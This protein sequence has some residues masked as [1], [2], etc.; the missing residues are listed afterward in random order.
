MVYCRRPLGKARMHLDAW[1]SP[2][3]TLVIRT[4]CSFPQK[5]SLPMPEM[6]R[7][8]VSRVRV[9][10]KDRRQSPRLRTRLLFSISVRRKARANGAPA[11]DRT[12]KGHTRDISSSGLAMMLPQ[13][14]LEGHHLAAGGRELEVLLELPSGVMPLVVIPK[15]YEKLDESEL[16]CTYLIG[17]RIVQV[18]DE[19]RIRLENFITKSL[20]G[21]VTGIVS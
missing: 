2:Q 15:R 12:L 10:F 5:G 7:S 8:V 20:S 11:A 9:Y 19:D 3:P 21:K 13:V 17:A 14:H 6:I 4:A 16:G 1:R 18:S